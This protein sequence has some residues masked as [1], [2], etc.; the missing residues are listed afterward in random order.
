LTGCQEGTELRLACKTPWYVPAALEA[1]R[2]AIA[3][4]AGALLLGGCGGEKKQDENEPA[5]NFEIEVL[6]AKFPAE[7][8]LAKRSD[9]V[10]KV[11]NS[12]SKTVPNIAVTVNGLYRRRDNPDLADPNRPVFVINGRRK[13]IGGVPEAKED[14]LPEGCDTAYVSTWA[15]GPLKAGAEKT[16]QWSVTA[17]EARPYT[18]SYRVSAGLDGK[19]KAVAARG[20]T[21]T[22][23]F[24]GR[25]SDA[26]PDTRVADDGHTIVKGTR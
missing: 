14:V 25:I 26:A 19:A 21:L 20:S 6:E 1:R 13:D 15:C 16:F 2:R 24:T 7:Q 10:I 9:L 23:R 4:G 12:G 8:K 18:I 3:L 22:G 5:G 17:V 11:R